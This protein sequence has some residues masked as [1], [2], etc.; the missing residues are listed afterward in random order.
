MDMDAIPRRKAHSRGTPVDLSS[1]AR[2]GV[3]VTIRYR[4]GAVR[5]EGGGTHDHSPDSP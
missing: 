2:V 4:V 5:P 3:T 1:A